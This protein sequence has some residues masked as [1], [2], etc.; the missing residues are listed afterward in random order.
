MNHKQLLSDELEL[1]A[2]ELQR[3][4][5]ASELEKIARETGFVK[6]KSKLTATDFIYLVGVEPAKLLYLQSNF[7]HT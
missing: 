3:Y 2:K 4:F 7:I 6:R 5:S 1:I